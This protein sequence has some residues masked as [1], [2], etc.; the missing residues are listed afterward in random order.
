MHRESHDGIA[1]LMD[2][3]LTDW[4][5]EKYAVVDVGS[6]DVNGT[7]RD[8]MD[9]KWSYIGVDVTTGKNVDV[10]MKN[11]MEIPLPDVSADLVLC[12]QVLEHSRNPWRIVCEIGRILRSGGYAFV[13]APRR[14]HTH[15]YPLDCFRILEDGMRALLEQG[16]MEVVEAYEAPMRCGVDC[17]GVGRKK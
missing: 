5:G 17:W 6:Q 13:V 9:D 3:Y 15:R 11:D 2:K 8:L 1:K 4:R 16:G 10:V 7:Y 12:G 14:F